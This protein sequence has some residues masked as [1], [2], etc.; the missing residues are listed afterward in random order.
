MEA[1]LFGNQQEIINKR[2]FSSFNPKNKLTKDLIKSRESQ[3]DSNQHNNFN[4]I[5]NNT[6]ANFSSNILN[7]NNN[8][9][10]IIPNH[11]PNLTNLPFVS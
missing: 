5:K 11:N 2:S 1:D 3:M 6:N 7:N 4:D 9:P 10:N 8:I